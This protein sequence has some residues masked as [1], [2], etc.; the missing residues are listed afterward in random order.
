[1]TGVEKAEWHTFTVVLQNCK[2]ERTNAMWSVRNIR[3]Q[4]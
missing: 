4:K 3:L 2:R 1:M